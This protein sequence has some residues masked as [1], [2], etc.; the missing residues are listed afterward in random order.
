MREDTKIDR[1]EMI[2]NAQKPQYIANLDVVAPHPVVAFHSQV[3]KDGFVDGKINSDNGKE[4]MICYGDRKYYVMGCLL[5]TYLNQTNSHPAGKPLSGLDSPAHADFLIRFQRGITNI[6][7]LSAVDRINMP[8][9][10]D[11]YHSEWSDD[12][13]EEQV[14]RGIL[15]VKIAYVAATGD[16]SDQR[17]E[18][19]HKLLNSDEY[20][21]FSEEELRSFGAHFA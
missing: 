1:S 14:E 10:E 2:R 4:F 19:L 9:V 8:L 12:F 21:Y 15:D 17:M 16:I 6:T 18:K 20:C 5:G 11:A 13:S 7:P 3:G